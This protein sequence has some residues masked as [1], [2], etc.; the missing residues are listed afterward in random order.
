MN[1]AEH[2]LELVVGPDVLDVGC[3][4]HVIK[5]GS[6][7]WL[8]GMLR[9]QFPSLAG[10]D[11]NADNVAQMLSAGFGNISVASA[12][13]FHMEKQFDTIVAG[14]VIEHLSNPGLF[15]SRC[16]GH[17]KPGGRIVLTTPYAFSLLYI[18]YALKNY[19]NT[20]QNDE[21]TIWFCPKTIAELATREGLR[22][23]QWKLIEDYEFENPSWPYRL[24]VRAITTVG[25]LMLPSRLR[26]NCMLLVLE[27]Q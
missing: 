3:A 7:Y 8:H 2:I 18:A 23:K 14:E 5:T 19:P 4:G 6:P 13:D 1:R 22:I 11:I 21:H 26:S 10:I 15:L 27:T 24:F 16:R 9:H 20:C 12:E 17:L 25:R